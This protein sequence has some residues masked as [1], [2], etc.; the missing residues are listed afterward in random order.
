MC[1]RI[2]ALADTLLA[3]SHDIHAHPELSF[4]EHYAHDVLTAAL[5]RDG[6]DVTRSSHGLDTAFDGRVG[7]EGPEIAVCLEYDALPGVGHACGHN[8]IAT[9]GLGASLAA[10]ALADEAGGRVRNLGTPAEEGGAGKVY[11]ANAG[12]FDGVDVAL[13][14]HPASSDLLLMAAIAAA[15]MA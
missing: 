3:L 1:E 14:I 4:E 8:I 7:S 5:E 13:M 6:I 15:T 12:A 10:A 9:A 11:M 2:D